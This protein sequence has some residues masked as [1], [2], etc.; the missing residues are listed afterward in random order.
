M[1]LIATTS[2]AGMV[3]LLG[4]SMPVAGDSELWL[5]WGL[6]GVVVA[7]VM[8]RDHHREKRMT[9]VIERQEA[10]MRDTLIRALSQNTAALHEVTTT[11]R[12]SRNDAIHPPTQQDIRS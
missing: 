5:Q 2:K 8:W 7:F 11:L 3:T 6:A 9:A 1:S 10:W 4:V 12:A